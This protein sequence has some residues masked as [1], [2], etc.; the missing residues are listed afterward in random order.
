MVRRLLYVF[1][2]RFLFE[3]LVVVPFWS[4]IGIWHGIRWWSIWIIRMDGVG[5]A[6]SIGGRRD[7]VLRSFRRWGH[8]LRR[9]H[10]HRRSVHVGMWRCRVVRWSFH[11]IIGSF[12]F[13]AGIVA[14]HERS[15]FLLHRSSGR[16]T[17]RTGSWICRCLRLRRSFWFLRR[18]WGRN[19][20]IW[21]V[22]IR[23]RVDLLCRATHGFLKKK[24]QDTINLTAIHKK[25][26]L[27]LC[28]QRVVYSIEVPVMRVKGGNE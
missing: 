7:C 13:P 23:L 19:C 8:T 9:W 28:Y 17:S 5:M 3:F 4:R 24:M 12:L 21:I 14:A 11:R 18:C 20:S 15:W 26:T 2:T 6:I 27:V 1:E 16:S 10:P 25:R 22:L